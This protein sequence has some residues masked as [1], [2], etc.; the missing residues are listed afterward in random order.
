MYP[1]WKYFNEVTQVMRA[2]N[3][4]LPIYQDKYFRLRLGGCETHL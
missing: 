3:R 4:V 1:R 2:E